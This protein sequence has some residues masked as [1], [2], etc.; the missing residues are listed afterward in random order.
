MKAVSQKKVEAVKKVN[1]KQAQK[2]AAAKIKEAQKAAQATIKKAKKVKK[3]KKE[4]TG[5]VPVNTEGCNEVQLEVSWAERKNDKTIPAIRG[6]YEKLPVKLGAEGGAVFWKLDKER[7][8]N[9]IVCEQ[10]P[11]MVKRYKAIEKE[12]KKLGLLC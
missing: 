6:T 8:K 5:P 11:K 3:V 7:L 1:I 9:F 12:A 2:G 10:D 4:A